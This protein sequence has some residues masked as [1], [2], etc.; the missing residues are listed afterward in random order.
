MKRATDGKNRIV[1]WITPFCFILG[2]FVVW[3]AIVLSGTVPRNLLPSPLDTVRAFVND[4]SLIMSH[5]AYTL[6]EAFG[7]LAIGILTGFFMAVLMDRFRVFNFGFKPL[8]VISQTVPT[9]AIAP[10]FSLWFGFGMAPKIIIVALTT[11]FPI[12]IGL[13]DGYRATDEDM[14]SL[15][16]SMGAGNFRIFTLLKFKNALPNFF[17]ALKISVTYSIVGAVISEWVGGVKGLGVYMIRVQKSYSYDKMFAAIF[18]VIVLSLLLMALVNLLRKTVIYW[19]K[20][21]Y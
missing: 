3:E 2:F 18:L 11:F 16:R 4:F 5:T 14:I 10:L 17:S 21:E 15:M 1:S 8:L 20:K 19:D 7:G 12:A 6:A 9:I 13:A